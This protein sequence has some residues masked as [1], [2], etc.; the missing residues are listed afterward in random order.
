M[1]RTEKQYVRIIAEQM[2]RIIELEDML[3]EADMAFKKLS[4]G[5]RPPRAKK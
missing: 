2:A 1:K 5:E 3:N 4:A